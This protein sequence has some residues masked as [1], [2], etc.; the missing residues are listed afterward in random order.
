MPYHPKRI[1]TQRR[2]TALSQDVEQ[3][4]ANLAF[5]TVEVTK[6]TLECTTQC[7][8]TVE[9]ETC[10]YVCDHFKSRLLSLHPHRINDVC[11]SDTFFSSVRSVQ[12]YTMF[13]MFAFRG[14]KPDVPYLMRK[15]SHASNKLRDLVRSIGA[16][17][18]VANDNAKVMTGHAWLDIMRT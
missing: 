10:E 1:Y 9:A 5:L 11:F 15:E 4:C 8:L 7:V 13:Q 12:G 18:V 3:W 6:K 14:C 16:M 2:N 17:K